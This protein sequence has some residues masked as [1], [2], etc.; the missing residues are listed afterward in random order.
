L[1]QYISRTTLSG[2]FDP[3]EP[4]LSLPDRLDAL[5]GREI[6]WMEMG[7]R[8]PDP[9]TDVPVFAESEYR[10]DSGFLQ[11]LDSIFL[12]YQKYDPSRGYAFLD[13]HARGPHRLFSSIFKLMTQDEMR[14]LHPCLALAAPLFTLSLALGQ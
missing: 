8:E 4:S 3:L 11:Y 5:E 12:V 7:L 10:P 13:M 6:A 2:V 14:M 1:L 9:I